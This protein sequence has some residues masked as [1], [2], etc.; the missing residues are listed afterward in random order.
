MTPKE[1]PFSEMLLAIALMAFVVSAC[2]STTTGSGRSLHDPVEEVGPSPTYD[3]LRQLHVDV[4]HPDASDSN[5][6]DAD[7]PLRTLAEGL[8]RAQDNRRRQ[9]EGTR[10][11]L[12][13]GTYRES[14]DRHFPN[15]GTAPIVIEAAAPGHVI[16]S[17]ADRWH[18]WTCNGD[19]CQHHWPYDW[20]T[21][22][23]PWSYAID[24]GELARRRELVIVD[25]TNLDQHLH[26]NDL[27]PGSFAIDETNDRIHLRLP[28][29]THP[30]QATI[31]VATRGQLLRSQ[32]LHNLTIK[33][34]TFQH[35]ATPFGRAAVDI[36]DQHDI[37][38]EDCLIHQNGQGGLAIKGDRITI[39]RCTSTHNG[40]SGITAQ[41]SQDLT[42]TDTESSHNNWRGK[43]GDYSSWAVGEKI[44]H[45][46]NLTI[47]RHTSTHNW[48]T[49]LWLDSDVTHATLEDLTICHNHR[50]GLYLEALQGPIDLRDSTLC[51][52]GQSGLM[53][54]TV[55][56]LTLHNVHLTHNQ[57]EQIR[58][59]G[60]TT[61]TFTDKS[62][63]TK[64]TVQ[65]QNWTIRQTTLTG[66]QDSLLYENT[67]PTTPWNHLMATSHIDH[68][69]YQHPDRPKPFQTTNG[70][71]T[72]LTGWQHTTGHDPHSTFEDR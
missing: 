25:G 20:G 43:R 46:H 18:D 11:V 67:L 10:V 14:I 65:N 19:T 62:T 33:G 64:T 26:Q 29:G 70:T 28:T 50:N 30:D 27:T 56:N 61:R 63:G 36:V 42:L 13:A 15:E 12:H 31:E 24:I 39:R 9:N 59:T 40:S 49:G 23:N 47:Q 3:H 37:L 66:T 60:D 4:R 68:N 57:G 22:E 54:A 51:E 21:A 7:S 53:A 1:R 8:Q 5:D 52:N 72:D 69:T 71:T 58:I 48:S 16:L 17:G 41:Q 34:L 35:A 55:E 44:L 6:G 2:G 45:T 32:S 38:L